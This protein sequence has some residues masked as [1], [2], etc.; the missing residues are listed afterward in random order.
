[1]MDVLF[2]CS[3]NGEFYL[4]LFFD[5]REMRAW[6][7]QILGDSFGAL[8][9]G[10][11]DIVLGKNV[12]YNALVESPLVDWM[13]HYFDDFHLYDEYHMTDHQNQL[14]WGHNV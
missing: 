13:G 14:E 6:T 9:F 10:R 3:I 8:S 2:L 1:M 12:C 11:Q 5:L 7:S 4:Q